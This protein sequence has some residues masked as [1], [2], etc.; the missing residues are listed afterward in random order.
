MNFPY[1]EIG[2]AFGNPD[3]GNK[4]RAPLRTAVPVLFVSG[5]LDNNTPPFQ[6]DE[7]RAAFK[8]STHLIVENAGHD[9][10]LGDAGVQQAISD[11]LQ[12][13]DV[14]RLRL[15]QPPL[16]FAPLPKK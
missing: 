5:T 10:L 15:A 9:S 11:Y 16:R 12:G 4:Y 8:Q 3:L 7:V 6:A 14:G 13:G 1:P 2:L